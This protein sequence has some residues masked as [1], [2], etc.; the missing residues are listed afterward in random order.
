LERI[1]SGVAVAL[2]PAGDAETR[3]KDRA[4]AWEGLPPG[5]VGRA[6]RAVRHGVVDVRDRW[7]AHAELGA[8][9]LAQAGLRDD[10]TLSR[11]Q[12]CGA[13]A[14]V[15]AVSDD[16]GV[17]SVMSLEKT[18]QG[19]AACAWCGCEGWPL[20]E[21]LAEDGGVVVVKSWQDMRNVVF[22][23][24]GE[25]SRGAHVV[26]TEAAAGFAE[27][28]AGTPRGALGLQGREL[29]AMREQECELELGIRGVVLGVAGCEGFTVP[30]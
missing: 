5:A 27:W 28:C 10:D 18:L 22:Q 24:T 16:V 23:G 9:G 3:G 2:F 25:T 21:K 26:A 29:I 13:L 30:C 6:L 17:A 19:G 11:G 4:G 8:A 7:Q 14:G 12:R 15:E 20:G 1:G